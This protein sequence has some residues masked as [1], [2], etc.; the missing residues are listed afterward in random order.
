[1][2]TA[3]QTQ[4]IWTL[5]GALAPEKHP[6]FPQKVQCYKTGQEGKNRTCC[7]EGIYIVR[8]KGDETGQ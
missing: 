4:E 8:G 1:M 3:L 6:S 5:P 2:Q 7:E